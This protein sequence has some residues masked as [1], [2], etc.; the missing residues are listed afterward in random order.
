MH[1]PHLRRLALA[2]LALPLA[3]LTA[4]DAPA[5]AVVEQHFA[6]LREQAETGDLHA[7][8]QLY[9]RYAVEGNTDQ[10]RH[11]ANHYNS[12]L[13]NKAESG[14]TQSMLQLGSRFLT[15]ADY[16][17]QDLAQAATWFS[18]AAEAGEPAAAYMLG[19][20]FARQGNA[21]ISSQ[22]YEQAYKLYT[23]RMGENIEAL[24]WVGFMQ[25][26]GIG[27]PRRVEEGISKLTQAAE[28]GSTWA[29]SQLFKTYLEGIGTPRDEA[30]AMLFA[31]KLA[32]EKGDG[33]MA[34]V[35]ATAAI[36]G[37]GMEQNTA[38]GEHYLDIAV[39]ANIP[40]AIY[41]KAQR[42]ELNGKLAEALP[43][44]NQAASMHQRDAVV[45]LGDLLLHGA[46]GVEQDAERGLALLELAGNR[47]DSPHAAWI[48]ANYYAEASEPEL[49]DS[50]YITASN[51]GVAQAAA[52]RGVLHLIPGSGVTWSPTEA[53]RWWRLGKSAQDPTCTLYLRLFHY[54]FIPLLLLL[55]F[56]V[57]AYI[58]HRARKLR[59]KQAST[60]DAA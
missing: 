60:P 44:Y 51:R 40:D 29:S 36:Y 41:M 6:T 24:Y 26:H 39:R 25:L 35:V 54:G 23:R 48:L 28:Q 32:D 42:L 47:L 49:A 52:R 19:E 21:A 7:A 20:I 57:P 50:W 56:G 45:R 43:L 8:Q 10:A 4:Q 34:Y 3:P 38:L 16:T 12:L 30:K 1:A 37:K 5:P 27:T 18:R 13:A 58:G 53:Y 2:L 11:W 59:R 14:D 55:V 31:R 46:E 9:M 22:A 17:P 15:G 33:I